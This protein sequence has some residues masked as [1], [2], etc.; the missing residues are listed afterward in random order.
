MVQLSPDRIPMVKIIV[1][2]VC[3]KIQENELINAKVAGTYLFAKIDSMKHI[4][5]LI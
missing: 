3:K 1:F 5:G 2:S 4:I